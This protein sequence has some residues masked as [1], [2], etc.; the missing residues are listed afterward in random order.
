M[1]VP[2]SG[3]VIVS[4]RRVVSWLGGLRIGLVRRL[5]GCPPPAVGRDRGAEALLEESYPEPVAHCEVCRWWLRCNAERRRDDHLSFIANVSRLQR[6]ELALHGFG[7]MALVG[8]MPLPL[9]FRPARGS[10]DGYVR[11]REQAR[12]QVQQRTAG[13][14]VFELLDVD[15]DRCLSRLPEP[16]AGDVFLDLEGDPFAREGGREY[17]F[18]VDAAGGQGYRARWAFDDAQERAAFEAVVDFILERWDADPGMH[19]FH[20]GHY[21]PSAMKRLMGR[22]G[23]NSR[24]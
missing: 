10:P 20:F 14:P 19:V 11:L 17:L 22:Y 3:C 2:A 24:A 7:T 1:L 15:A 16:S 18:G 5:P 9:V 6:S 4:D 8:A 13:H 21:E 23:R 12:V